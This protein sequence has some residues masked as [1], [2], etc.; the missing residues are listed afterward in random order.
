MKHVG[1]ISE[2]N[3]FHNGHAYL[4]EKVKS[5]F[6][7]KGIVCV[8]SGNFVQRGSFAIQE[9][10]SRARSAV[11]SGVDLVLEIPFPFSCLSAESFARSGVSI[12]SNLGIVDCLA[13]GSEIPELDRL[14]EVA[15]RLFDPIFQERLQSYLDTNKGVGYP[16]A[17][18]RIYKQL[19]QNADIFSFSNASLALEY[20]LAIRFLKS[21]LFP[22]AV[23]RQG[24]EI[25]SLDLSSKTP[26]ATAIRKAVFS[27]KEI[28]RF[29]P[30]ATLSQMKLDEVN[31][32]FPV[33]M[34]HLSQVVFYL[35]KTKTRGELSRLYGFSALCDRAKRFAPECESL[36]QLVEKMKNA[37]VT[38]SR[39]RRGLLALLCNIPRYAES[40]T[41]AYTLVLA[42][43]EKGRHMLSQ[44]RKESN[45]SVFTKPSHAL[46]SDREEILHQASQAHLA[47]EIYS[48]AFPK[49][50]DSAYFFKQT[51]AMI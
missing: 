3:P 5:Q 12:L 39:I 30:L 49:K 32:R 23:K 25:N 11:L 26:S 1:I 18:E 21:D 48:M 33:S 42:A 16:A 40:Q 50:Q 20:L 2:F 15:D 24:E 8:M 51:P 13:F 36:E 44:I 27:G 47:D 14:S 9:K 28:D 29:V 7:E 46:R 4:I 31:G 19:Y 17:R 41:P 38:D 22:F 35:L 10:Y 43:N 34:E 6:P 45:L 37:S